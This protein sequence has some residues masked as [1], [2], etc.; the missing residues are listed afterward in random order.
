MQACVDAEDSLEVW[1]FYE[2]I[3]MYWPSAFHNILEECKWNIRG[4]RGTIE[5]ENEKSQRK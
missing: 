4:V 3:A 5:N 1:L 2:W